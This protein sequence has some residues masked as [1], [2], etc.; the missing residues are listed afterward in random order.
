MY[1]YVLH[2]LLTFAVNFFVISQPYLTRSLF[3]HSLLYFLLDSL[4]GV[5]FMNTLLYTT[6]LRQTVFGTRRDV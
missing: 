5:Y 1:M 4:V 2:F 6:L 3:I